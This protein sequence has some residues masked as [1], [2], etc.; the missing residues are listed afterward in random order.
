M[1]APGASSEGTRAAGLG[2]NLSTHVLDIMTRMMRRQHRHPTHTPGLWGSMRRGGARPRA[3]M[4]PPRSQAYMRHSAQLL[5]ATA[6]PGSAASA[7]SN[8]ACA[9]ARAAAPLAQGDTYP[10]LP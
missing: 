10:T 5:S 9:P 3:W 1:A 6:S 4:A 8:S 2:H 7:A